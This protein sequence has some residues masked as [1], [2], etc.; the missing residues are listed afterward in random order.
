MKHIYGVATV[1]GI[2]FQSIIIYIYIYYSRQYHTISNFIRHHRIN[3]H[4]IYYNIVRYYINCFNSSSI[5]SPCFD[6]NPP[7]TTDLGPTDHG[8]SVWGDRA[9]AGAGDSA[10]FLTSCSPVGYFVG[11]RKQPVDHFSSFFCGICVLFVNVSMCW[12]V[13]WKKHDYWWKLWWIT[14]DSGWSLIL[15]TVPSAGY[16]SKH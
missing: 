3:I 12:V 8:Q 10:V 2:Y 16:Q 11:C 6:V 15:Q 7:F 13:L 1:C 14:L 5:L 4:V 9:E